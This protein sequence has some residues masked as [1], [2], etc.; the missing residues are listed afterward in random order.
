MTMN[1][2]LPLQQMDAVLGIDSGVAKAASR[3]VRVACWLKKVKLRFTS[4]NLDLSCPHRF[5]R[6]RR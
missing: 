2:M 3:L 5:L 1:T 4:P 6:Y